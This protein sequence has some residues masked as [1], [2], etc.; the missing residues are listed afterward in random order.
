MGY[1]ESMMRFPRFETGPLAPDEL[2]QVL[3]T[4][5]AKV[6]SYVLEP[7]PDRPANAW[8]YACIDREFDLKKL[9]SSMQRAVRKGNR[10]L[11]LGPISLAQVFAY[12]ERAFCDMHHRNGIWGANAQ[13]FRQQF[14]ERPV[15]EGHVY[16][17]AWKGDDLAAF[18]SVV[19]VEDWCEIDCSYSRD[20]YLPLHSNDALMYYVLHHYM[21][22]RQFRL[23]SFG[24]SSVERTGKEAGLH[25][26]KTKVGFS[27][28]PVHRT[29]ALHPLLRP[30]V[31][32]ATLA[33]VNL[34]LRAFPR[35]RV[36]KK[37]AG[38]LH[39]LLDRNPSL[40]GEESPGG[41]A[42]GDGSM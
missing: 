9:A 6:L 31:N 32:R 40:P 18:F 38:L 7:G 15:S 12:G 29:F 14:T 20:D 19:E 16:F 36:L 37:A 13:Q 28:I 5:G 41:A 35:S 26:F 39:C 22:E 27:A 21:R 2:R 23:A 34:S 17:G 8:L 42:P 11:V 3:R 25:R 4:S 24:F 33:G 1:Y 30:F 10:E